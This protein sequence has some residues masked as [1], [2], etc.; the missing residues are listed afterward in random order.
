MSLMAGL[1]SYSEKLKRR[2]FGVKTQHLDEFIVNLCDLD[3]TEV[4][5]ATQQQRGKP[6]YPSLDVDR[7]LDYSKGSY[8]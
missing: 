5:T 6:K 3:A 2:P 7:H 8:R 1:A 4:I